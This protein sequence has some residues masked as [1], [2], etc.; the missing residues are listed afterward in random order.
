MRSVRLICLLLSFI[1]MT[2]SFPF[3]VRAD[4]IQRQAVSVV[5][6]FTNIDFNAT[7]PTVTNGVYTLDTK[8]L[9][10]V[11]TSTGSNSAGRNND[12][13]GSN[14]FFMEANT[15]AINSFKSAINKTDRFGIQSR[16]KFNN[17][18]SSRSFFEVKSTTP[19]TGTAA[20][21]TLLTFDELGRVKDSKNNVIST[22]AADQ[23]LDI[24]IDMDSP[25]H[26]YSAWINGVLVIE[27]VDLGNYVGVLQ[28]KIIQNK[29]A[30]NVPSRTSI[31]YVKAGTISDPV[32]L[33][34][35]S[36]QSLS[37]DFFVSQSTQL[38]LVKNPPNTNDLNYSWESSNEGIVKVDNQGI[39][40]G[41]SAGTAQI[42]VSSILNPS[43][44]ASMDITVKAI[45]TPILINPTH[46]NADYSTASLQISNNVVTV[47]SNFVGYI[48]TT[49]GSN[50]AG[51]TSD[52]DNNVLFMEAVSSSLNSYKSAM[53]KTGRFGIQT[54]VKFNNTN[55]SRSLF[56]MKSMNP[57]TG[58]P[59]WPTLLVFDQ[60]GNIKDY[61]GNVLGTYAANQWYDIVIDMDS[62]NH[63]Y[64]VWIDGILKVNNLDLGNYVGVLQN[65]MI[66][67]TNA[68]KTASRTS[69]AYMKVGDIVPPVQELVIPDM[70]VDKGKGAILKYQ[71]VP[72]KAFVDKVT[73]SSS[74][75]SVAKLS[76]NG[77]LALSTGS[78][79]I[80]ATESS[81]GIHT[82][83]QVTV[84][85]PAH[86]WNSH[87]VSPGNLAAVLTSS[88]RPELNYSFEQIMTSELQTYVDMN[89]SDFIQEVQSESAK[90]LIPDLHT[91]FEKYARLF[92]QLYKLTNDAKYA[93][94]A[95]LILYYQAL[96]YPR[97]V[98][99]TN[100]T[101]FWGGNYQFPQDAVYAYGTL[102]DT[103][104]WGE[105]DPAVTA[106][107]VKMTIEELWLKPG[108]Y[109]NIRLVNSMRLNNI[110]PYGGRSSVVTGMLLNDPN[111]IREV[112]DI[113]DRL[114]NGDNYL[115]DGM[116]Y[117]ETTSYGDQAANNVK[118]TVDVL[119]DWTDPEGY[120]DNRF[121]LHLNKTD[122]SSRWPLLQMSLGYGTEKMIYPDGTAIPVNDTY[123][124]TEDPQP[125]P[126]IKKSLQ[127]IELPGLGYYGLIQGDVNEATQAG[128][129]YQ[130]TDLGFSGGHTHA[131]FLSLD[132][133]GAGVEIL[134]YTGYLNRTTY[135]DGSGATLR[136]PSMRPLWRN[137]PWVWRQDG[138]NTVST[139]AWGKP[140]LLAYDSGE[141]N[142]KRVQLVEGS[143][144][145]PEG[146]GAAM[147][148]RLL[149]MVNLDGNRNYTFDLTRMQGG[150]AHEIYQRGAELEN[151]DVQ[152][153]GIQLTDTGKVNLQEY[154]TSIN[155]TEGLS[156]DRNLLM[157]PKAAN[158]DT[159]FSFTWTGQQTGASIRT[160]MNAVDGSNVFLSSI[161]T[162]RRIA[163]KGDE[164]ND[165]TPHLTRRHI[166]S[167]S[168]QITQYGAVHEIFRQGQ[169]GE[170]ADVAWFQSD[171]ADPMTNIAV[172]RSEKYKDIIYTSGDMKER[173]FNG[174]TFAGNIA[175]ARIDV[176]TGKL[177]FS[178]V[179]GAGKVAVQDHVL[180]GYDTQQFEIIGATT[181]SLNTSLD[182][183]VRPNTITVKG[184]FPYPNALI[185]QRIQTNFADGSGYGLKVKNITELNDATV[186]GVEN[187]NPFR[188][189]DQGVETMFFPKF[190]IPGKAYVSALL[191]KFASYSEPLDETDSGTPST[192]TPGAGTGSSVTLP[193]ADVSGSRVTIAGQIHQDGSV[194]GTLSAH[195]LRTAIE[196][197][198]KHTV[199]I[200][201]DSPDDVQSAQIR[202]PLDP[203]KGKEDAIHH[204][205]LEM[206]LGTV[207]LAS[208]L[209]KNDQLSQDELELIIEK[210]AAPQLG[211][212]VVYDFRLYMDG[213]PVS[214]FNGRDVQ[215]EVP[216]HLKAGE[217][218]NKV[219]IYFLSDEGNLEMIR[220]GKYNTETNKITFYPKHFSK[221]AVVYRDISFKDLAEAAWATNAIEGLAVRDVIDGIGSHLFHPNGEVTRAEFTAMLMRALDMEDANATTAFSDI[222]ADSWS[223]K[224]IA[225]AQKLGIIEG[226]ED[227][228][229]GADRP[230]SRQDMAVILYRAATKLNMMIPSAKQDQS[231]VDDSDIAA[232]AKVSVHELKAAGLM[233][234]IS[235]NTFMPTAYTTRAQAA[236]VV[237]RFIF[238][239]IQ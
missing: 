136:Y 108:A 159:N 171:D 174:I 127:N 76:G 104:I 57:P 163:T 140:A 117:E 139:D 209:I 81:T 229:F 102:L 164:S 113:Y 86:V 48:T 182:P 189:T 85:E 41:I 201:L 74:N 65:K 162:A 110:T 44:T 53:N 217:N 84:Q 40:T 125:L 120:V 194:T 158:G 199:T 225:S 99:N 232:Y 170:I 8:F 63:R 50:S 30:S 1:L 151:M 105:L 7:A 231:F 177:L 52:G 178:Y 134:P 97:I 66:Q 5:G 26:R 128:L 233:D 107:E 192:E 216:Y 197:A 126:I 239:R 143:D 56:E 141:A 165:V 148:R 193:A 223:F 146:K 210:T 137:M 72:D 132:L 35:L 206:G 212:D 173:S 109:E 46:L 45:P 19:P 70:T 219:V 186:I 227:G 220:T 236:T 200:K 184:K 94:K 96:D 95:A 25:N 68:S 28:N 230:I 60:S 77:L 198:D 161:P 6:D 208:D 31:A 27:N 122:L 169:T 9:G 195:D 238:Q 224:A 15:G 75:P 185:G 32:P 119:K 207:T 156:T 10:T 23:W 118:T 101:D 211:L 51:L 111:M 168:N 38:T 235:E 93:K 129:L 142:G 154:L 61:T 234:G 202:I 205:V 36:I 112:I 176:T 62:P 16:V 47:D 98:V 166:V 203:F 100:Y 13:D 228:S 226:M 152:V 22:Y 29:N 83:F 24:I 215:V 90:I 131:N 237:F 79:M 14:V 218:P 114:M 11:T 59:A 67:N 64:S 221:Y 12:S 130:P 92:A 213:K 133:W 106:S 150:Q 17:T 71:T 87:A 145:G 115:F 103:D 80:T 175:L 172:V 88:Y 196:H 73:W 147:N 21:P 55:S 2:S 4:T 20:W 18:T 82:T 160:F 222:A 179:Y 204:L 49:A 183:P 138:A 37:G 123:G 191:P 153:Q 149:M 181:A 54:R 135:G 91:K 58:T 157:N 190:S 144:P 33:T 34:G 42:T 89:D 155:S 180:L 187:F 43:I 121:G 214:Q 69:I 124:K 39:I 116:W 3:G 78:A 188:V 167:D